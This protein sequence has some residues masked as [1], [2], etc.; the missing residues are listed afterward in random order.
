MHATDRLGADINKGVR[1]STAS[2][3]KNRYPA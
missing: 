3:T 2:K 1:P